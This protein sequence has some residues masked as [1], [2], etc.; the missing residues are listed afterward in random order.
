[1]KSLVLLPFVLTVIFG[2][3]ASALDASRLD[4]QPDDSLKITEKVYLHT[5][6]DNYYPGDDIWFKAYLIEAI[7]R[8]LTDHSKN[9][10]V[11][12]ISPDSKIISERIIRLENGLG[13]GDF[14]LPE[15]LKSG[16]YTM[17][18]YTNYM[19]N[20]D[21]RIFFRKIITVYS[22]PDAAREL[23]RGIQNDGNKFDISFF[24]EGGS[25]TD[26]VPCMVAFKTENQ[27][28]KGCDITGEVHSSDGNIVAFFKSTHNGMGLFSFVPVRGMTYYAISKNIYGDTA[29]S[30]LPDCF[31]TGISMNV[32]RD[33]ENKLVATLKTNKKTLALIGETDLVLTASAHNIEYMSLNIRIDSPDNFF[34]L[35]FDNLPPG[36]YSLTLQSPI[37]GPLCERLIYAG[38]DDKTRLTLT[39]DKKVYNQRDSIALKISLTD[40]TESSGGAF[41]SLSSTRLIS[42][43]R[44]LGNNSSISSWFLLESEV[45]GPVE[46]P[47]GYFDQSNPDRLKD[48]D[49]LLVTQGWRDFR[50]KYDAMKYQPENGFSITGGLRKKLAN[51]PLKNARIYLGI[52]K[53]EKP[54][55][56]T[57]PTDSS[58]RFR[59]DG[60]DF[61]GKA[62]L[63]A[64]AMGEND[65]LQGI[66]SLDSL[67][68]APAEISLAMNQSKISGRSN[69]QFSGD[70]IIENKP[71]NNDNLQA[72][73]Q[74]AEIKKSIV[75]KYK[76]SDTIKPGEVSITAKRKTETQISVEKVRHYL[77][78]TPDATLIVTPEVYKFSNAIGVLRGKMSYAVGRIEIPIFVVDGIKVP[79]EM[80]RSVPISFIERFDI[81]NTRASMALFGANTEAP[82][83]QSEPADGVI[84]I[85]TRSGAPFDFGKRLYH[86]ANIDISGYAEPRIFYSPK[87]HSKLE[88]DYK[89]DLRTTL[90]W[91]P[92]IKLEK[93]REAL[94]NYY[95]ADNPSLI[96]ITVEGITSDGIPVTGK[97]DYEVK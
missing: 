46:D 21:N 82:H 7:D 35:P 37:I 34:V 59:L 57:V 9:L 24:P 94:L 83:N 67:R 62:D 25:L 55:I 96:R 10:H 1:M 93:N 80:F 89:P 85:T 58:G 12:L 13:N 51:V 41:L 38:N 8:T 92:D 74:Y 43:G 63:I 91:E 71:V 97:L 77:M 50:W 30:R 32:Y 33:K 65:R 31:P 28:G 84:S 49:L 54:Q 64:S 88:S 61:S 20:F 95:N 68:Y 11:E 17:R 39:T 15:N 16:M 76:L 44:D 5:D 3:A 19:R 81:L 6:R 48:L 2:S 56:V 22:L 75:G 90:L 40:N 72:Y 42:R 18:A 78:T 53:N 36:I 26:S 14:K 29:G 70:R 47:A 4:F 45:R 79:Y 23:S 73:L 66:L 87:H 27:E 69:L 60:I 86:S 52:F